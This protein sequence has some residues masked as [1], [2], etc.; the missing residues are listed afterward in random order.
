[1]QAIALA[2]SARYFNTQGYLKQH[3]Q[4][5]TINEELN[6]IGAYGQWISNLT[7]E[8]PRN[9]SFRSQKFDNLQG[10]KIKARKRLMACLNQPGMQSPPKIETVRKFSF[11]GLEIEEI[12]WQLPYG[13]PTL[14]YLLKP[15]DHDNPL[16][17]IVA[18][19]DHGGNKYFGR[20]KITCTSDDQHPMMITH[21]SQYYEGVAWANA[22]S[23]RGYAVLVPD[24]FTFGSRRVRLADVPE[25][26]RNGLSDEDPEA[27]A[28]IDAYNRWAANHEHI[29]AKS[30][31]SAGT[32]W[33]AIFQLEDKIAI[34]ILS[35]RVDVDTDRI[36]CA[37]L[38]G[39]GL[40]TVLSAGLD[41][42]IKCA[43][44]VGF[45]STWDDFLLHKSYTHTWMTYIPLIAA[46]L[47]FP[48][49]L[50]LRVPLPTLVQ[51]DNEDS[52]FT[53]SQ[54]QRADRILK[55]IYS[56]AGASNRYRGSF[57]PGPHKFDRAMQS[58]AFAW[59][60]QWLKPSH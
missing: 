54:M 12:S 1:M 7:K 2:A 51:C 37:G 44:C 40:R 29:L 31:F 48:E 43:V 23:K 4:Q 47:D 11:D 8:G 41:D 58:E 46:E 60:D 59:F 17:G 14:S 39:G 3:M 16:P 6:L 27:P 50:G 19:H 36:G 26:I 32:C 53:L 10:W 42:R 49:I 33:P 20:R 30:L 35:A 56:K 57:H 22:L 52:L 45:M 5:T 55:E 18:F 13:D 21:Q 15:K 25:H 34:D 24:V 38:S 9:L 28:N